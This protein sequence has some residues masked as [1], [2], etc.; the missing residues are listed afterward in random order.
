MP[1]LRRGDGARAGG[2]RETPSQQGAPGQA[3]GSTLQRANLRSFP[4]A[5]FWFMPRLPFRDLASL[6][7]RSSVTAEARAATWRAEIGNARHNAAP[8]STPVK[9]AVVSIA[10]LLSS[11]RAVE[12]PWTP[13]VG[14]VVVLAGL[15]PRGAALVP[16]ACA[17]PLR[18]IHGPRTVPLDM[19]HHVDSDVLQ[20]GKHRVPHL[21]RR[22]AR[23]PSRP[24]HAVA[25][26]S[27]RAKHKR[28]AG[29]QTGRRWGLKS[30]VRSQQ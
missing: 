26:L 29:G 27:Q 24:R 19:I 22:R 25:R 9:A 23:L 6:A 4:S 17:A 8:T 28:V 11:K 2:E 5:P 20:V 14:T 12:R 18:A 30:V 21:R 1:P 10:V 3:L 16:P 13:H 15:R 7:C